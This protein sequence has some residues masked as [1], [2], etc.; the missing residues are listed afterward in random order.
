MQHTVKHGRLEL[1][2][3]NVALRELRPDADVEAQE[4]TSQRRAI[5]KAAFW[6]H[7]GVL[8]YLC[9]EVGADVH[10]KD[11]NGDTA[12]HDACRFGHAPVVEELLR[13]GANPGAVNE[14]GLDCVQLALKQDKFDIATTLLKHLQS[15]L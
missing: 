7:I 12:L 10:A 8:Q 11:Y 5:H 9:R 13:A 1:A 4:E 14:E 3:G 15:K 2:L 6:V